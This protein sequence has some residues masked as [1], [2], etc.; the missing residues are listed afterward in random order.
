M[1]T[2]KNLHILLIIGMINS[3]PLW[4]QV[5][6]E[7]D[8]SFNTTRF[9]G[10]AGAVSA[11]PLNLENL[12][13]NPAGLATKLKDRSQNATFSLAIDT[14]FKP[15]YL[16][17][18]LRNSSTIQ[19]AKDLI[20]S[21][22]A[23]TSGTFAFGLTPINSKWGFGVYGGSTIY[24]QGKPFPFGTEGYINFSVNF[25]FAYSFIMS[26]SNKHI[27]SFGTMIHPE[28]AIIKTLNGK[29]VDALAGG[30][31]TIGELVKNVINTPVYSFPVDMG[32]IYV[33]YDNPYENA[34]FRFS[35]VIKNFF[36][37]YYDKNEKNP[38]I[39]KRFEMTPGIAY[40][41]PFKIFKMN[42]T[43]ILSAE[44]DGLNL[45]VEETEN[46]W[47][48][49]KLGA[50]LNISNFLFIQAG[51]ASGYPAI[52]A[53]L[54]ILDLFFGFSFETVEKGVYIGDNPLSVFRI[55]LS[56]R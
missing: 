8:T 6:Q 43:G 28:I 33:S 39:K 27:L 7:E 19:N 3:L 45:V 4:S 26:K 1:K 18:I 36:N 55:S 30:T 9:S 44:I 15:Q 56:L 51:L 14:Y 41:L 21:S 38:T 10:M 16:F 54:R 31:V 32:I 35:F 20:T 40:V 42:C 29:D 2:R 37:S 13:Y 49:L 11:I 23:G 48:S 34:E 53:E 47:K 22:G 5:L 25:P 12:L 46:F 24:L 52:G 17:P 50:E